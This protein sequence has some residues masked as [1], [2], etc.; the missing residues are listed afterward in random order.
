M[1]ADYQHHG[2]TGAATV[3]YSDVVWKL[4]RKFPMPAYNDAYIS[5]DM[6]VLLCQQGET[7]SHFDMRPMC[8]K[9]H[10]ISVMLPNHI[11]S[12]CESSDD[13]QALAVIVPHDLYNK[14]IHHDSF[15]NFFQ[16]RYEP[17]FHLSD[18]QYDK[19]MS[20][21]YA[22][23]VAVDSRHAKRLNMIA[24]ILDVFFYELNGYREAGNELTGQGSLFQRFYDLL[25]ENYSK[26]H[27]VSWYADKL[28]LTPKHFSTTIR[29]VT[30]LSAGAWISNF[31]S[32]KAKAMIQTRRNL[33]LQEIGLMLGF[34][35]TTSFCRFFRRMN[36]MSPKEYRES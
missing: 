26:H 14:F 12:R 5:T 36:Q 33:N 22:L 32:L 6:V 11:I 21:M 30:G 10:D 16:Y 3:R 25:V 9:A 27:E 15:N 18:E 28:N 24:N 7:R 13:Y 35:N 1:D 2:Q 34:V 23:K 8:F 20:I 4:I 31:L 19:I 17:S 29:M